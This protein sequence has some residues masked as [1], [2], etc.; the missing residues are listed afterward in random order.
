MVNFEYMFKTMSNTVAEYG[1][2]K[3]LYENVSIITKNGQD[4]ILKNFTT[5]TRNILYETI[6]YSLTIPLFFLTAA[7]KQSKNTGLLNGS[8]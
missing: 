2:T 4:L 1:V 6:V 3:S 8:F 5:P 7:G